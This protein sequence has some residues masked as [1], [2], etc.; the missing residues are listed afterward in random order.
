M[1]CSPLEFSQSIEK[2]RRVRKEVLYSGGPGE[3]WTLELRAKLLCS[4]AH[5]CSVSGLKLGLHDLVKHSG[6]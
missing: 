1:P 6:Q 5:S 3:M 4:A 2:Q